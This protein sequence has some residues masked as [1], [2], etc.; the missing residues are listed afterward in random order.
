MGAATFT[1]DVDGNLV[2][3]TEGTETWSFTYDEESRLLDAQTPDGTWEY[4]Y[5][6]LGYRVASTH[7]GQRTEFLIDP[8]VSIL[9]DLVAE[10]DQSGN[11][12]GH[13]VYALGLTSRVDGDGNA[14]F[15]HF[16]GVA[17]TTEVTGPAG[18]VVNSYRY[19]PFGEPLPATEGT[20]N[21]FT[22]SG[23][24]GV[25]VDGSGLTF[26]RNR[27][28]VPEI[29]Q[30]TTEDPLGIHA[31]D[32]NLRR[33]VYN[34]PTVAVDPL[35][36]GY[37]KKKPLGIKSYQHGGPI[38]SYFNLADW[39]NVEPAHEHFFFD[40]P[41]KLEGDVQGT[42][43]DAPAKNVG[44]AGYLSLIHR[45]TACRRPAEETKEC[46]S[47]SGIMVLK[48]K[49]GPRKGAPDRCYHVT[50]PTGSKSPSTTTAW[51]PMPG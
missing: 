10:Y 30:F 12:I 48:Q 44:Y 27:E 20:P 41:Q 1:Y 22:F 39:F 21:P 4:E 14:A 25:N 38:G 51:W 7:N 18:A 35:G 34:R 19:L 46:A 11:L 2:S 47:E 31:G 29:G 5:D 24:L 17:N 45:R 15:Y 32:L 16:D 28:Y 6:A 33:Y 23:Q 50:T 3:K 9:N 40:S 37:W 8:G 42:A 43:T 36:L 26:M 49:T 13:Y